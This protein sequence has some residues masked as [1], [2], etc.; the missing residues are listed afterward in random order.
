MEYYPNIKTV[1]SLLVKPDSN[2]DTR[3]V[4]VVW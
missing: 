4:L 3:A 1:G 2:A